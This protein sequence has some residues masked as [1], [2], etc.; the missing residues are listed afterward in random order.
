MKMQFNLEDMSV[1]ERDTQIINNLSR[2]EKKGIFD[3]Y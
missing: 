1:K 3:K 2:M